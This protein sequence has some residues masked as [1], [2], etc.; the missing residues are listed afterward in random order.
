[1][2]TNR[3]IQ[4]KD[5]SLDLKNFRTVEQPGELEA[6]KAMIS[7]DP[8]YFWAL[9]ESLLDDGYLPIENI[10][11]IRDASTNGIV[12]KEGN[13]RIAVLKIAYGIIST[14]QLNLPAHIVTKMAALD[15]TWKASNR[16]VPCTLF[17]ATENQV[18]DEIISRAHGKGEK[19]GRAPWKS[20]AR[21]RHNRD[22]NGATEHGLNLLE[23]YL[24]HGRNLTG[25]QKE[26]F[27]GDYPVSVLDA[28]IGKV[29]NRAGATSSADFVSSYP[30]THHFSAIEDMILAIGLKQ[31]GFPEVR[32]TTSD[33][34]LR[35]GFPPAAT[36]PPQ[37]NPPAPNP[38]T[39]N[40]QPSP[41]PAPSPPSP[42]QPPPAAPTNTSRSVQSK[43]KL[44]R[45][46]GNG[47]EKV[48]DLRIEMQHLNIDKTPLAFCFLLRSIFEI[49]AKVYCNQNGITTTAPGRSGGTVDRKLIDILN[50]AYNHVLSVRPGL[51]RQLYAAHLELNNPHGILSVTSM[52]QLIHNP[53]FSV[54]VGDVCRLFH[55]VYPLLEALN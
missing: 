3:S 7:I 42:P 8:D 51:Q 33:F 13:R 55:N 11:A 2:A 18:V 5:L 20:V 34:A 1:M 36:P 32:S 44:F 29:H 40:P 19:A 21:A 12:V 26:R 27:S 52:N 31:V 39:P 4:V 6:V 46:S 23:T 49:S 38:P 54:A 48:V 10:I 17:D 53:N 50:D 24:I 14:V 35:F 16:R 47:R 28:A 30:N 22:V 45:P 41:S 9:T 25:Q 15:A 37:P 43:L